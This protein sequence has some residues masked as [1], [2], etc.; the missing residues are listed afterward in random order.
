MI[1]SIIWQ[2]KDVIINNMISL[3]IKAGYEDGDHCRNK[4]LTS[5]ANAMEKA[6]ILLFKWQLKPFNAMFRVYWTQINT[7]S[8]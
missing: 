4:K 3:M 1:D 7:K 6:S 5:P 8:I 2:N